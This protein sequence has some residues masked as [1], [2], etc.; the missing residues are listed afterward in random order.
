[1]TLK[2]REPVQLETLNIKENSIH[3]F[4]LPDN[5]SLDTLLVNVHH[6]KWGVVA[7][8]GGRRV[9]VEEA[10]MAVAEEEGRPRQ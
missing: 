9:E 2:T 8:R 5:L 1:M 7:E 3:Y 4:I 10:D 6:K